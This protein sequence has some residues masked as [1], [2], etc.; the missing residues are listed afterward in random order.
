MATKKKTTVKFNKHKISKLFLTK[1][2]EDHNTV[3][4][5]ITESY[6]TN[7]NVLLS[8]RR[9]SNVKQVLT[10]SEENPKNNSFNIEAVK[11]LCSSDISLAEYDDFGLTRALTQDKFKFGA[12]SELKEVFLLPVT[13][14]AGDKEVAI[15][16][17]SDG[18]VIGV[19]RVLVEKYFDLD[20]SLLA[21]DNQTMIF[22]S[23]MSPTAGI[24]PLNLG[25]LF[26]PELI[27]KI[28][29]F[30]NSIK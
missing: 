2:A 8:K 19:D 15:Y 28:E 13:F 1:F 22:D 4:L 21:F 16:T 27:E 30:I 24:M 7:G 20:K 3:T 18:L 6:I 11:E 26:S 9:V 5:Y 25:E 12:D 23:K 29:S 14:F 10:T 17:N